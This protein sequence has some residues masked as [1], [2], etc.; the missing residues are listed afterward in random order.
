MSGVHVVRKGYISK[1]ASPTVS[2]VRGPLNYASALLVSGVGVNNATNPLNI[3][4]QTGGRTFSRALTPFPVNAAPYWPDGQW[5]NYFDG[6]ADYLSVPSSAAFALAGAFTFELWFYPLAF[7]VDTNWFATAANGVQF[8]RRNTGTDWGI[9]QSGVAWLL[10]TTTMPTN[11]AWNH[12]VIVRSGTGTN[13]TSI[14]LNGVRVANGTVSASFA[15]SAVTISTSSTTAAVNGYISNLRLVKDSALYDPTQTT[16]TVPTAPL[17]AVA[18]TSLLTCQSNRFVDNS[19]N[20]FAITVTGTPS[21]QPVAPFTPPANPSTYGSSIYQTGTARQAYYANPLSITTGEFCIEFWC[22]PENF[23]AARYLIGNRAWQTGNNK[24]FEI[25]ITTAGKVQLNA[26]QGVWNNFPTIITS[27]ASLIANAWNHV[28]IVRDASNLLRVF[29]N[30]VADTSLTYTQSL[31]QFNGGYGTHYFSIGNIYA[32]G[33]F[34]PSPFNGYIGDVRVGIGTGSAIYTANFTPPTSTLTATTGTVLAVKSDAFVLESSANNVPM[35]PIGA[36]SQVAL[37]PFG[38][39]Y[40]GSLSLNGSSYLTAASNPAFQVGTG[41][42]TIEFWANWASVSGTSPGNVCHCNSNGT[43]GIYITS[44]GLQIARYNTGGDL[45]ANVTQVANQWDHYAFVRSGGTGYIFKNGVQ[46]ATGAISTNYGQNGFVVGTG[47]GSSVSGNISN[48]RLV[49]GTALYT[50]NFTPSTTPLTA[51]AGTSILLLGN[52]VGI[53]DSSANGYAPTLFGNTKLSST[54]SVFGGTSLYLDGA[55]DYITFANATPLQ[56]T[57]V[58]FQ[59]ECW[60]YRAASGVVHTIACK[61]AS[62]TGWMLQISAADKLTFTVSSSIVMTSTSSIPASTWAH[63]SVSRD[64]SNQ[65]RLFINGVQEATVSNST[66]FTQTEVLTI[67]ADRSVTNFFNGYIQDLRIFNNGVKYI[68]GFTAPTTFL[69]TSDL[70]YQFV[71]NAVYGVNGN[72]GAGYTQGLVTR[73]AAPSVSRYRGTTPLTAQAV[74]SGVGTVGTQTNTLDTPDSSSNALAVTRTGTPRR[75]SLSP[76]RTAGYWSVSFDGS[77]DYLTAPASSAFAFG[78]NDFTI[79]GWIYVP[80]IRAQAIFDTRNSAGSTTGFYFGTTSGGQWQVWYQSSLILSTAT[81]TLNSWQHFAL[82]RSGS[83][84]TLYVNGASIASSTTVVNWTDTQG[85]IGSSSANAEQM[86]GNLSNLRVV[87]GT[88]VYTAAFTPP[89][90]PLTAITNTVLLTCNSGSFWDQ[91]ANNYQLTAFG[92]ITPAQDNPWISTGD[93]A[94]STGSVTFDG[95]S[96]YLNV[97]NSTVLDLTS[98]DWTCEGWFWATAWKAGDTWVFGKD[99]QSGVTYEQYCVHIN[100]SRKLVGAVG[101]GASGAGEQK[102]IGTTTVQLGCWYHF[103]FVKSG[104]TLYLFLNGKL[105]TSAT[106]TFTMTHGTY[107][108]RVGGQNNTTGQ[109]WQ[110]AIGDLRIVKGTALYTAAF[111]PPTAPLTA[112]AGTSYLLNPIPYTKD[113][114]SKNVQLRHVGAITQVPFSP[115]AAYPGSYHC[116]AIVG[117]DTTHRIISPMYN[118]QLFNFG[119]QDFT[120]EVWVYVV[121]TGS[122]YGDVMYVS[123]P[124]GGSTHMRIGDS[125]FGSKLQCASNDTSTSTVYTTPYTRALLANRWV[126]CALTRQ[127]GVMRMF[128]DGVQQNVNSGINPSTY[129]LASWTDSSSLNRATVTFGGGIGGYLAFPHIVVGTA[130]YT[131]SF[132]KPT[133]PPTPVANTVFYAPA[134]N[135]G[136]MDSSYQGVQQS[137]EV[138][139]ASTVVITDASAPSGQSTSFAFDGTRSIIVAD[140]ANNNFDFAA[141]AWT[142][143]AFVRFTSSGQ[144]TIA[145]SAPGVNSGDWFFSR[146]ATGA[147]QVGRA[148]VDMQTA[149]LTWDANTW[150]HVAV[151]K[152]NAAS[153]VLR[154]YRDGVLL[155]S[156]LAFHSADYSN[157]NNSIQL[158]AKRSGTTTSSEYMI[159]NIAGFR[160]LKGT[161]AYISDTYTVPTNP[162]DA[163][164]QVPATVTNAVYGTYKSV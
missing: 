117:A 156:S 53:G 114:S 44:T 48:F 111:T 135:Y 87:N 132:T 162:V 3:T 122:M 16:L 20:N 9:A 54:Q 120:I 88:A 32:D 126:H 58:M 131:A 160:V 157:S 123:N 63:V 159:G 13:Q 47:A 161:A 163:S 26:S 30:G 23:S 144:M 109:D 149:D 24:G 8:G 12:I 96:D 164:M 138:T 61:G 148:T 21:T 59:L 57:G 133:A 38:S 150:Y 67:G 70:C 127:S 72:Y 89:T 85:K 39:S 121:N 66:S 22:N 137:L 134:Q 145:G 2:R 11:N 29:I 113:L 86:L 99:G 73:S 125:G 42:F 100:S 45:T 83:T 95:S 82:V 31:D 40:P 27:T 55:G 17:T 142:V 84:T 79:E 115:F 136:I 25:A 140:N 7:P 124:S 65:M 103:A 43:L 104:T 102:V 151:G 75:A 71:S 128:V 139:N 76:Y 91:S 101:S 37:S 97:A 62:T 19:S 130:L 116:P 110:G 81:I 51:V 78:T 77:G 93:S 60:V 5:G 14:F 15:Q 18:G 129:P 74:L 108:L 35:V 112:V 153:R 90:A 80:V 49:K 68:A 147:L 41:D 106:Q 92:N 56:F 36:P 52:N 10:T 28:A 119:T 69:P 34:Q 158:G 155:A 152:D 154:I 118:R 143:E 64:G 50:A 33:A 146:S 141:Q 1:A 94:P 105:E 6:N 107:P 46:V 4:D 98:G